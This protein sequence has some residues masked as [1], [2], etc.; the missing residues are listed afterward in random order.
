MTCA[1]AGEGSADPARQPVHALRFRGI[2]RFA[3]D[4]PASGS[5]GARAA[6][7][8]QGVLHDRLAR[9]RRQRDGGAADA[10][11]RSG[12]PALS[13]RRVHGQTLPKIAGHGSCDGFCA[14]F[15]A[16]NDDPASGGRH[17]VWGPNRS[18][19]C[20][21]PRQSLRTCRKLSGQ[22]WRSN[23]CGASATNC[24]SRTIRS[25]SVPSATLVESRHRA[26][27]VQ[28]RQWTAYQKLPAP[29]LFVCEDNGIGISVKTPGGWVRNAFERSRWS[30]LFL[31]RWA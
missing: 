14:S 28:R 22:P 24:R 17:K 27:G 4:Q 1:G 13:F 12:V 19:Y 3:T 6:R 31:R 15:A 11:Y 20:R 30:R 25:L 29:V 21:R 18:G 10:T 23:R 5:D 8:E 9:S 2:V 16:S 26:D 7:Q